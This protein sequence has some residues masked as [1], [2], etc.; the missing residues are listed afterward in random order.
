[1]FTYINNKGSKM[2]IDNYDDIPDAE[3]E[4]ILGKLKQLVEE[5]TVEYN[6]APDDYDTA[7]ERLLYAERL[8]EDLARGAELAEIV[9]DPRLATVFRVAAEE[10]LL[11]KVTVVEKEQKEMKIQINDYSNVGKKEKV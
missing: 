10:Y 3:A 8:L 2:A 7:I 9:S 5:N 6:N 11:T 4:T 1:M